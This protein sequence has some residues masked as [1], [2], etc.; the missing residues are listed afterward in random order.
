MGMSAIITPFVSEDTEAGCDVKALQRTEASPVGAAC[1]PVNGK[2]E[3]ATLGGGA[4][5]KSVAPCAWFLILQLYFYKSK[6][7]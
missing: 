2:V 3:E 4:W 6:T 5:Y 1:L 7:L